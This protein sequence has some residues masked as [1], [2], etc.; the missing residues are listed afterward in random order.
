MKDLDSKLIYEAYNNGKQ[1]DILLD[2]S[3]AAALGLVGRGLGAVRNQILGLFK[4]PKSKDILQ[5]TATGFNK[6]TQGNP[7]TVIKQMFNIG[8]ISTVGVAAIKIINFLKRM[9][10]FQLAGGT[11]ALVYLYIF[12]A[13]KGD[14]IFD[15]LT[16]DEKNSDEISPERL[17]ELVQEVTD[18]DPEYSSSTIGDLEE[19]KV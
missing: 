10:P 18:E 4:S 16:D 14:K 12:L 17:K 1:E 11:I 7:L 15:K 3:F 13:K 6:Y 9:E 19:V 2:E 5:K 8:I